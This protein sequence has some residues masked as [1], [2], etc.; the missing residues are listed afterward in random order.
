MIR[1]SF[2]L[3]L[4]LA[5]VLCS[6]SARAQQNTTDPALREKAFKLLESAATQVNNLQSPENRARLGANIADSLWDHDQKN[7]RALFALVQDDIKAGISA[8]R[9]FRDGREHL[10]WKVFLKLRVDTVERIAKHDAELALTFLKATEPTSG[11]PLPDDI[12]ESMR[13]LD[14]RLA[15]RAA[16]NNP[17]LALKLARQSLAEGVSDDL[18]HVLKQL[19]KTHKEQAMILYKEVVNKLRGENLTDNWGTIRFAESLVYS[20]KPATPNDPTFRELIG[21]LITGALEKGCGNKASLEQ[22][23]GEFCRL[24]ASL[25]PQLERIDPRAVQLKRWVRPADDVKY[26]SPD[27]FYEL[28]E[29]IE[30]GSVEEILAFASKHPDLN[31]EIYRQAVIKASESG[32]FEQARRIAKDRIADPEKKRVLLDDLDRRE[33]QGQTDDSLL[34]E[35]EE[36][37]NHIQT[38]P[39]RIRTLLTYTAKLGRNNRPVALKLLKRGTELADTLK[40]GK[41]QTEAQLALAVHYCFAKSDRGFALMEPLVPKLNELVEAAM[42]LD[43]YETGYVRDGEWIMSANGRVG[44]ILT[45]LSD[46][47]GSF[48]WCDFDRAVSLAAQFERTEIRL[49]AHVKLAQ[50]ILAGPPKIL[51]NNNG[52]ID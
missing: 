9:N 5:V 32:D 47:A 45:N 21:L 13:D 30:D 35:I 26:V 51:R 31:D 38:V 8:D 7:A 22:H 49:M 28:V 33:R 27:T 42:K 34:A 50:A 19:N 11:P 41:D 1:T 46:N 48:A 29:I 44:A 10:Q 12:E 20:F 43:G 2:I 25:L 14:I 37:L 4:I 18:L 40:P 36:I 24:V 23:E 15:R 17:D 3:V 6:D 39:E 16:S 52:Y